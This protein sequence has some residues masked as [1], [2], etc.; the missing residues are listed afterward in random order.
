MQN[1]KQDI[2]AVLKYVTTHIANQS[3]DNQAGRKPQPRFQHWI[4]QFQAVI[5]LTLIQWYKFPSRLVF[6]QLLHY[7]CGKY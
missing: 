4:R 3:N 5:L 1:S 7:S 2:D 6:D